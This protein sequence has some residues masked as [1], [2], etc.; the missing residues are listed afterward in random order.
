MVITPGIDVRFVL[1]TEIWDGSI[2]DWRETFPEVR[3]RGMA[4]AWIAGASK[5]GGYI[6]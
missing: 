5:H 1:F 2:Y 4:P 6:R 3:S